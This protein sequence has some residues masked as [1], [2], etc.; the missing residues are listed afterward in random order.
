MHLGIV[1]WPQMTLLTI[2]HLIWTLS[3]ISRPLKCLIHWYSTL[4]LFAIIMISKCCLCSNH[5]SVMFAPESFHCRRHRIAIQ[6]RP[7][8]VSSCLYFLGIPNWILRGHPGQKT[9]PTNSTS[10]C[11][12]PP[13]ASLVYLLLDFCYWKCLVVSVGR[14][15]SFSNQY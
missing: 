8:L 6:Y 2:W 4:I 13:I 1:T 10:Y 3:G 5:C 7:S 12:A 14:K 11:P 15:S 9:H